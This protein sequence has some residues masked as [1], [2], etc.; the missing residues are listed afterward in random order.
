MVYVYKVY[1]KLEGIQRNQLFEITKQ[2]EK[3]SEVGFTGV[4]LVAKCV[5]F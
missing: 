4:Q 3:Q 2:V 5:H 1:L